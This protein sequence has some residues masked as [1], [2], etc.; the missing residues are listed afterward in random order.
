MRTVHTVR[1]LRAL[2]RARRERGQKIAFVPTMGNLHQGHLELVQNARSQGDVVVTSIFVNPMQFGENED[3]DAY[4]RTLADDQ[5]ALEEAGNDVIFAPSV[6]EIYPSGMADQTRV[7]VPRITELHCGA[8]RPGHFTGVATVVT[9]LLNIVQPDVAVFGDKDYQQLAVIRKLVKDL[10]MPVEVIGVATV[11][12][13]DGLAMSSRNSFLTT[14]ERTQAPL[15]YRLLS[16][17]AEAI[18]AG[19]TDFPALVEKANQCLRENGFR[20]DYFNIASSVTLQPAEPA[21]RE[22]TILAAAHLGQTRL[23]DNISL[24]RS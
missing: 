10:F 11:R 16:E 23:I 20:P 22:I 13:D 2:L 12:E 21:D 15:L 8:S 4:P 14:D 19:N 3:L 18:G 9:L 5:K 6:R 1:E 17:T 7:T 24:E